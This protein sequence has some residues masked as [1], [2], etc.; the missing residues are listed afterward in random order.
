MKFQIVFEN[1]I[2]NITFENKDESLEDIMQAISKCKWYGLANKM[3]INTNKIVRVEI[4]NE[5]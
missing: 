1:R 3:Y 4:V 2:N 5:S